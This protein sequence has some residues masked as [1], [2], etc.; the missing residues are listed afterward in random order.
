[1]KYLFVII[2]LFCFI[3]NVFAQ[4]EFFKIY[5][6]EEGVYKISG[7][8]LLDAGITIGQIDPDKIQIFSDGNEILP[9]STT[10]AT[11]QLDEISIAVIDGND[12]IFDLD[13]GPG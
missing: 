13:E 3:C 10:E 6:S 7:Q 4:Q 11:P 12:S 8:D 2:C 9:Y 5:L 1:M